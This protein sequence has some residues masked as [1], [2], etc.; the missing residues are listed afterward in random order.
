MGFLFKLYRGVDVGGSRPVSDYQVGQF[1][2]F[3]DAW[4]AYKS[5]KQACLEK[6]KQSG[7]EFNRYFCYMVKIDLDKKLIGIKD[8]KQIDHGCMSRTTFANS[9]TQRPRM[10]DY[11]TNI[12]NGKPVSFRE[13]LAKGLY[14]KL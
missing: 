12:E 11:M 5:L 8:G 14:E 9:Y 4:D 13:I 6:S 10:H 1:N 3:D 2:S 7:N